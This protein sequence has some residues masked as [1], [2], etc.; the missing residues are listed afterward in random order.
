MMADIAAIRARNERRRQGSDAP[1]ACAEDVDAL[2]VDIDAL[3]E[4][5]EQALAETARL[6]EE[7]A[8]L[9]ASSVIWANLYSACA[10][11][12]APNAPPHVHEY[13]QLIE[14]IRVL[15]EAIEGFLRECMTCAPWDITRLLDM[16]PRQMCDRCVRAVSALRRSVNP[17]EA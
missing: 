6:R 2:A 5:L 15:R 8:D 16:T 10:G 1:S 17:G 7:H 13:S 12:A 4:A 14:S 3:L 9:H 11:A